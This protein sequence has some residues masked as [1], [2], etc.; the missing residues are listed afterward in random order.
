MISS[1][2]VEGGERKRTAAEGLSLATNPTSVSRQSISPASPVT[3]I[4]TLPGLSARARSISTGL[5][6]I[7]NHDVTPR[8]GPEC[9]D[10]HIRSCFLIR[11]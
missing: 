1:G 6:L 3:V 10:A 8:T 9:E 11:S 4:V 2:M 5:V 7:W